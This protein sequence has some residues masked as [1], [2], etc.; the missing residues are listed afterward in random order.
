MGCVSTQ[1]IQNEPFVYQ[2]KDD[3]YKI[4]DSLKVI[5]VQLLKR[6]IAALK[7]EKVTNCLGYLSKHCQQKNKEQS[8]IKYIADIIGN[9]C[10]LDFNKK[11][12]STNE[13]QQQR[14]H[15]ITQISYDKKILEFLEF[16]VQ[17]TALDENL[18][19]CGSNSLNIL[20]EM[21]VDLAY[22][23]FQN[24]KIK[25]TQLIG[26]NFVKC[27][28]SG[29]EFDN[30]I[31]S[32]IN[33][34]GAKLFNCKWK[35]LRI[36]ELNKLNGHRD[37]VNQVCFSPDVMTMIFV[38][39]MSK[40]EKQSQYY[41]EIGI[42]I[43][44]ASHEMRDYWSPAVANLYIGGTFKLESI[45]INLKFILK[46]QI[47]FVSLLMV[48]YQ[49]LVVK[50]NS[51]RLW[52]VKTAQQYLQLDGHTA[53]IQSVC[54]S[55]DNT[56]LASGSDDNS[57]CLWDVKTGQKYHQ[58]DGHTGYVNAVCFSPDCTTLASG[59]FDY[60][61]RFWD[62]KTGQQAAKLDG[63]THEVRFVCFSP[64]G[65]TLASASWDN[66]VFI[67]DV[68]KREQKVSIDGHT[69]QVTSVC[70]SPD[71]TALASGSYDNSIRLWDIQTILQYHQLDCHIDSI[72]SV[73]FSP[74]GTT[75]ASGSDDYTI[76]LW[77]VKT[78]QQK[79]KLE[80]HSSYVISICFSPDGFTLA[81]GS[82]DCSVRLWDV[83]QGQQK[84]QING[85]NDYVR[86]V[87]FSHDGNTL[88]SG[89]DDLTIRLWNVETQQVIHQFVTEI[90][91]LFSTHFSPDCTTLASGCIDGYISLWDVKTGEQ[92]VSL[93]YHNNP[94]SSVCFLS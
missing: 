31:I 90:K 92:K 54:F 44:S 22:H 19:Q 29:S 66:S 25:N 5:D 20:V 84:A 7:K 51:I 58:L 28:L 16:L 50:D 6:I 63:H 37:K 57:I 32:G 80:G 71:G 52:D 65:T 41:K 62:V 34:N 77:D 74:D 21:K 61:I 49:H 1:I 87:C 8:N 60:S 47:Q 89:C 75:L 15:L 72:R 64:D 27:D 55:S 85:H 59:S 26:A 46:M 3:L 38:F 10:E 18:I 42:S 2:R 68:I 13:Q 91:Y 53:Q 93:D 73:C 70:F 79:I 78:G 39:G 4:L 76:R 48:V 67:W 94:V 56:K 88:A 35:N 30:V 24:I 45:Y 83:K 12:Y 23:N 14:K 86:S 40:Q 82:G 17:L 9:I 43:Q 36:N 81:S 69:K 33:L 11:N